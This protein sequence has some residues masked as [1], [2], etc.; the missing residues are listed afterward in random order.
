MPVAAPASTRVFYING[1]GHDPIALLDYAISLQNYLRTGE[2]VNTLAW[3]SYKSDGT[4]T[5]DA[6]FVVDAATSGSPQAATITEGGVTFTKCE[7]VWLTVAGATA[8][9][10]NARAGET[11]VI[12][13]QFTTSQSRT[14]ERSFKLLVAQ[15]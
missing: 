4:T 5:T 13:M 6:P 10:K 8:A 1:A 15:R 7:V 3:T 12:T 14:D 9:A 11:G 2:S